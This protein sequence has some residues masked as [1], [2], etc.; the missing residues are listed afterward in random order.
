MGAHVLIID[1]ERGVRESLQMVLE[2]EGFRVSTAASGKE[3]LEQ[4]AATP[5]DLIFLDVRMPGMDGLELLGRLRQAGVPAPVIVISGHGTISTAVQATKL[6]AFDFIEK[7][8]G[9]DQVLLSAKNALRQR[10][11]EEEVE[12]LSGRAGRMLGKSPAMQRIRADI[13]RAA[14]TQATVLITGESGTGKEL[15]AMALHQASLR[16]AGEF[17]RVNCAAI[18]EELIESELFGHEK[19]SFTGAATRQKGKF[20]QADGG[21]IFLDEVG[22]MS[23]RTQSKVLRV[24][25]DGEVE[26]VGAGRS[27]KVDVRVLAAT[28]KSRPEEIRSGRFRRTS[29]SGSTCCPSTC[30]P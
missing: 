1:D 5:P 4:A 29:T 23:L 20:I 19:G 8:L 24:L 28:N 25:Q 26:P 10:R 12:R 9:T 22:D 6:G 18:P 13:Q 16:S 15:V 11:L 30:R 14:P 3:G 27:S 2:Y 7:P 17:I 21:T